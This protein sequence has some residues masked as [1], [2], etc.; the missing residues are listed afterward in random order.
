V[1][2]YLFRNVSSY[3]AQITELRL[4][5]K[6]LATL[7]IAEL[8]RLVS[9]TLD[10]CSHRVDA[11]VTSLATRRLQTEMRQLQPTGLHLGAFG[12]LER[13]VQTARKRLA[14]A[15]MAHQQVLV[16]K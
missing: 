3:A 11:W 16:P 8:D 12:G 2:R 13:V 7:S 6:A 5:L 4:A 1:C 9:E 10:T 14:H 15:S